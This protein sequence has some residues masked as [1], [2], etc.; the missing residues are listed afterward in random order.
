V[1]V[2]REVV[3]VTGASAGVGRAVAAAFAKRGAKVALLAR[4]TEGLHG[5]TKDVEAAGGRALAIPTDVAHHEEVEAA[6]QRVEET[7]GPIDVWVNDAMVTVFAPFKEVTAEEFERATSVTYLGTVYGTMASLKRMLPRDRGTIVQVGS[8]L[9]YR[10]IPLQAPYCGS[11]F[12]VRGF[13]DS[14]RTELEHDK[15]KVWITTVQ[16]PAVNTPQFDWCRTRLPNHPMP[17]PPIYQPDVPAEAI[18][19]AAHHRRREVWV[20]GS[21]VATILGNKFLPA[22]LDRYL[23]MTGYKSQQDG[24]P[25]RP[26]RPDNLFEPADG[27]EDF[28]AHGIFDR[29][30]HP[31]SVQVWLT[32]RRP[33]VMAAGMAVAAAG[34]LALGSR[35]RD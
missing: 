18:Y 9:S 12:A 14:V 2:S 20:G 35:V 15:S 6:A 32:E 29:K 28:G 4:G 3:V 10:A 5:A 11:K 34:A 17:V 7:F 31:R 27:H 19:W 8:A 21:T 23:A 33:W 13:T 30:A 24:E 22:A 26:G 25:V 1:E 16:L